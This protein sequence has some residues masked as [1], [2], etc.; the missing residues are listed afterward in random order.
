MAM[1]KMTGA[2]KPVPAMKAPVKSKKS[3]L[4]KVEPKAGPRKFRT[5]QTKSPEG[6]ANIARISAQKT[7]DQNQREN[8]NASRDR[9]TNTGVNSDGS[10]AKVLKSQAKQKQRIGTPDKSRPG[11][12]MMGN[13]RQAYKAQRAGGNGR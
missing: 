13:A 8:Y 3:S 10:G 1:K 9:K 2:K 6:K 4:S 11:K 5:T 12:V 7:G